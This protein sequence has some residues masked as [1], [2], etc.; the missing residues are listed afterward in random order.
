[1]HTEYTSSTACS[2]DINFAY[3]FHTSTCVIGSGIKY[4]Y[5]NYKEYTKENCDGSISDEFAIADG[6]YTD[7][8]AYTLEWVLN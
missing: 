1:M 5:P 4:K 6:C 8:N 7:S 2:G 3:A